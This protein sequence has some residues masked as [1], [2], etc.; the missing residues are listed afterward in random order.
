MG[1]LSVD[2]LELFDNIDEALSGIVLALGGA[3]KVGAML[4]PEESV[5]RAAQNVTDRLN[6][7]RRELFSPQQ[8]VFLLKKA[9]ASGYHAG[10][11]WLASECGYTGLRAAEPDEV[12]ADL[13]RQF[14]SRVDDLQRLAT[15][16]GRLEGLA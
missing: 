7:N 8:V 5:A 9:R 12:K 1:G 15:K 4:W 10:M 11:R 2:E 13:Q 16:I 6:S 3:K 14:I